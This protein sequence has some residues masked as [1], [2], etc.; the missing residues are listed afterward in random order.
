MN[1]IKL[2]KEKNMTQ[3]EIAKIINVA[4]TTY[5]GYEKMTSEPDL[6][7]LIKLADFF[8][9]SLDYLCE[10]QWNNQIGYIQD[11]RRQDIINFINLNQ[12]DFELLKSYAQA[13][14]DIKNKKL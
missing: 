13:L 11:D 6:K 7:T 8:N 5:L 3:K 2:R 10:R 12:D 14:I 4:P 9:V 1:L